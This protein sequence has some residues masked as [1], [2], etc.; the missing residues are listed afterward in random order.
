VQ[1]IL[2]ADGP[3]FAVARKIRRGRAGRAAFL[4]Q[5]GI[6]VRAAKRF[7]PRPLQQQRQPP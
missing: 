1:K 3:D 2:F 7:F 6:V 5:F 4:H